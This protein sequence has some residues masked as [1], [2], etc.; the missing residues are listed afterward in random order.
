LRSLLSSVLVWLLS[1]VVVV[2]PAAAAEVL[3]VRS[4]TLL[5]VGDQNRSYGVELACYRLLPGDDGDAATRWLR[6]SLPRRT[7][8]NLRPM[9]VDAGVLMARVQRL[10]QGTDLATDLVSAGFGQLLPECGA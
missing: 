1:L 3:Q 7:R 4:A 10:D 8:V 6:S 2:G 9:G 5:Q